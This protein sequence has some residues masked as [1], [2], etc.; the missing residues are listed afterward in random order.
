MEIDSIQNRAVIERFKSLLTSE[1]A[2]FNEYLTLLDAQSAAIARPGFVADSAALGEYTAMGNQMIE[3]ISRLQ[4]VI[5]PF[6]KMYSSITSADCAASK[7]VV[8][9]LQ[10]DLIVLKA[11]VLEK[12]KKT[13]ELLLERMNTTKKQLDGFKNPY[14]GVSSVF[15]KRQ[16]E[17]SLVAQDA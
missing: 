10:A 9:S 12:N 6:F 5:V 7:E 16:S 17:G 3:S 2:K 4:K 8:A 15:M 11:K 13:R 1:R 14:T